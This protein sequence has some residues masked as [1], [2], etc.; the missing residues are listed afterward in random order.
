VLDAFDAPAAVRQEGVV[1]GSAVEAVVDAD[2]GVVTVAAAEVD[3]WCAAEGRSFCRPVRRRG[4]GQ[5]AAHGIRAAG[6]GRRRV[7]QQ[8]QLYRLTLLPHHDTRCDRDRRDAIG[9]P[10]VSGEVVVATTTSLGVSWSLGGR[11]RSRV[12]GCCSTWGI[13]NKA[14]TW[15][16][17]LSLTLLLGAT[18]FIPGPPAWASASSGIRAEE[19]S[20]PC[21]EGQERH[22]SGRCVPP[23]ATGQLRHPAGYCTCGVPVGD[24]PSTLASCVEAIQGM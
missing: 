24:A 20:E 13:M 16:R 15:S 1:A 5:P 4:R 22:K 10:A 9:S 14:V 6:S 19:S 21:P 23:C 8:P 18:S 7:A 2:G 11:K 17:A 12:T 3:V